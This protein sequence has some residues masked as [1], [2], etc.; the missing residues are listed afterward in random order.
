MKKPFLERPQAWTESSRVSQYPVEYASAIERYHAP[1]G[2]TVS[3]AILTVAAAIVVAA[4]FG[5]LFFSK[6]GV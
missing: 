1:N 5:V 2:F 4:I 3:K 6:Q